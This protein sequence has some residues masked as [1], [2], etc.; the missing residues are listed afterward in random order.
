MNSQEKPSLWVYLLPVALVVLMV[1]FISTGVIQGYTNS[2]SQEK[3]KAFAEIIVA[4]SIYNKAFPHELMRKKTIKDMLPRE[5]K[6][7]SYL[8]PAEFQNFLDG[9]EGENFVGIGVL[10]GKRDDGSFMVKGVFSDGPARDAGVQFGDV[11]VSVDGVS[12]DGKDMEEIIG[13]IKGKEGEVVN[14]LFARSGAPKPINISIVR[15]TVKVGIISRLLERDYG[16]VGFFQFRKKTVEAVTMALRS[17]VKENNRNLKGVVIDLR[18]NPG[19]YLHTAVE[20]VELFVDPDSIVAIV[21]EKGINRI[22]VAEDKQEWKKTR[23]V[24]LV[25]EGSASASELFSASL[26]D[27]K[28]AC[29]MGR[30]TYGKGSVQGMYSYDDGSVIKITTGLFFGPLQ[31]DIQDVGVTPHVE[32]SESNDAV[33]RSVALG[34]PEIASS[35]RALKHMPKACD[36]VTP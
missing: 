25:N 5:D 32:L 4:K 19:G 35:L 11:F 28:R 30:T 2:S 23:I 13:M 12:T 9:L 17:L 21:K 8:S 26:K 27:N 22:F 34:N 29:I 6:Y 3:K 16:Y 15:K 20:L 10:V 24:V 33:V 36:H 31:K 18:H 14:I 7:A 1:G